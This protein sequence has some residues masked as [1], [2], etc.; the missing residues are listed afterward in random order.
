MDKNDEFND[1]LYS[2]HPKGAW[3][4]AQAY[5]FEGEGELREQVRKI[6]ARGWTIS[7]IRPVH[8]TSSYRPMLIVGWTLAPH[9]CTQECS[10]EWPD[11]NAG[12]V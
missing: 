6:R 10:A 12:C 5:N 4:R 11:L 2:P 8:L 3:V 9:A 1:V 7:A